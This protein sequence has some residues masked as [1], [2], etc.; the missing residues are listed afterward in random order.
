MTA[1]RHVLLNAL[2]LAPGVSGGT[3][4]YLRG[5]A[6][7]LASEFP[8]L[9]LT[10]L[11]TRSGAEVLR[12]DGWERFAGVQALACEDG[13]RIRRLW[14]EQVS[15]PGLVGREGP[16]VVHSLANVAPLYPKSRSI[17]TLHDVTF[18]TT[19]TFGRLTT[20][21]LSLLGWLATRRADALIA[22]TAAARD[23]ICSRLHVN[24]ARFSVIHHGHEPPRAVTGTPPDAIRRRYEL[25]SDRVVLCVAAKRPNKNQ[26]L[27]IRAIP[28]LDSDITIVL[29]G[30]PEPYDRELRALTRELGLEQRVRFAGYVP[31]ADLEGLWGV[32]ACAAFPTL[33]E[34]FGMPVLDA[35]S[36]GVPVAASG[37]PVLREIGGEL[38]HYFS[39]HD[40]LDAARAITAA[41]SDATAATRGPAR[42]AQFTWAAAARATHDVYERVLADANR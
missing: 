31:D 10:V 11:T 37:L 17:V 7:A 29:A 33:A 2:Y 40:P 5:L 23:E 26:E 1:P 39:P 8:G 12:E 30:H 16:D 28:N 15:L 34:G 3:E 19:N 22:V 14:A 6:P 38:P 36:H 20:W 9:R 21:S 13:Q 24:P 4:T 35:L 42:A 25:G 27:L 18:M 41:L 32:A